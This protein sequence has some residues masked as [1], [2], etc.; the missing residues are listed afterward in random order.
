MAF[1]EKFSGVIPRYV[2]VSSTCSKSCKIKTLNLF[3]HFSNANP[4]HTL[5][6]SGPVHSRPSVLP[7]A[8]GSVPSSEGQGQLIIPA[9]D[10][11]VPLKDIVNAGTTPV[12]KERL[13]LLAS[14]CMP[15]FSS[16]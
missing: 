14:L 10:Y 8:N 5:P 4:S 6:T 2:K 9:R 13:T 7:T 11:G 15:C 3:F 16:G 1:T 12:Y